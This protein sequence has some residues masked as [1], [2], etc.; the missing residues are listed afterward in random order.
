M[1][2]SINLSLL[3]CL[4]FWQS[5]YQRKSITFL[6]AFHSYTYIRGT[7]KKLMNVAYFPTSS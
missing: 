2:R 1:V 4:D 3:I 7:S 6:S 5:V